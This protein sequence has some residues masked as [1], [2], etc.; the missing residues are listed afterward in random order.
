MLPK[1]SQAAGPYGLTFFV[2]THGWPGC[3]KGFFSNLKKK[4]FEIFKK[5]FSTGNAGPFS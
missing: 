1:A 4:K 2:D 3:V 5:H